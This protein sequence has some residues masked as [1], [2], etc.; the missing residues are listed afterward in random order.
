[1]SKTEMEP[2]LM[3]MAYSYVVGIYVTAERITA[4]LVFQEDS[5]VW[6][7]KQRYG[8]NIINITPVYFFPKS[9]RDAEQCIGGE[10][11]KVQMGQISDNSFNHECIYAVFYDTALLNIQF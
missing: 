1:M 10:T 9:Y 6:I 7:C 8:L 4:I 5:G 2:A 3:L 11:M